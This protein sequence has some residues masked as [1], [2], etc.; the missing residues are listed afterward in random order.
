MEDFT[1][2]FTPYHRRDEVIC[3][4]CLYCETET[5]ACLP[6]RGLDGRE[7]IWECPECHKKSRLSVTVEISMSTFPSC[8]I[9][10]QA[11][12]ME[13]ESSNLHFDHQFMRCK[14]CGFKISGSRL[15]IAVRLRD[16]REKATKEKK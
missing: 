4:Y 11:H 15:E 16:E 5:D 9:N 10:G 3:P 7:D 8:A 1:P 14:E 2:R 13:I 12:L 6:A